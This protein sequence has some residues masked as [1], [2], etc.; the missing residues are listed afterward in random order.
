MVQL[1]TWQ[2]SQPSECRAASPLPYVVF[3]ILVSIFRAIHDFPILA[4]SKQPTSENSWR[5]IEF[6]SG[7]Y[8]IVDCISARYSQS[9]EPDKAKM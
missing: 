3:D 8:N 4:E 9:F 1:E 7:I 2:N 5:F 6:Y